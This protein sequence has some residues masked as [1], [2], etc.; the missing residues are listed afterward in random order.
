MGLSLAGSGVSI[1]ERKINNLGFT[2]KE[3]EGGRTV[4]RN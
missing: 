1:S 3:T 4:G 2:R